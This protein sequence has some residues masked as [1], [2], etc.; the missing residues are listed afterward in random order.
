MRGSFNWS[1]ALTAVTIMV[2]IA[3]AF[4]VIAGMAYLAVWVA[5]RW[6]SWAGILLTVL[7]V[8]VVV[9]LIGGLSE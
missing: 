5:E 3:V 1:G 4:A 6:G 2:L 8:T 9:G 7:F